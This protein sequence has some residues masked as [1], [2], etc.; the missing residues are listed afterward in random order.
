MTT[1]YVSQHF[2]GAGIGRKLLKNVEDLYGHPL[3]LSTWE[4]NHNALAFYKRL[5]F[6]LVG[7]RHFDLEGEL[8]SNHVLAYSG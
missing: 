6:Q 4:E 8:H 3:W 7:K 5:G 2:Q 1:L